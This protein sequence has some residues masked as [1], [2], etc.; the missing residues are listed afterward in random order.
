[1]FAPGAVAAFYQGWS[2]EG[3]QAGKGGIKKDGTL[4]H[5]DRPAV[6]AV[7]KDG[8]WSFDDRNTVFHFFSNPCDDTIN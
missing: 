2:I 1:M 4:I 6:M 5:P 3:T 8:G 7:F